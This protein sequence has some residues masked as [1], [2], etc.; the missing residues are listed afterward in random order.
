MTSVRRFSIHFCFAILVVL[1]LSY[2]IEAALPRRKR[3][4]VLSERPRTKE[5]SITHQA[6]FEIIIVLL[7]LCLLPPVVMFIY[8]VYK[9]PATPTVLRNASEVITERTLGYLSARSNNG[10]NN[11]KV[12]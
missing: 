1:D 4:K 11:K 9:D 10:K 7:M 2:K 3:K 8:N 12:N 5:W 6:G